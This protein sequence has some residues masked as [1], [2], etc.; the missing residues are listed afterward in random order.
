M[1]RRPSL[2][3]ASRGAT[4]TVCETDRTNAATLAWEWVRTS[5]TT[6]PVTA[7]P[8]AELSGAGGA[9]SAF[10]A[11]AVAL[12]RIPAWAPVR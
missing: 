1:W 4:L 3:A 7:P 6:V 12:S 11:V 2:S 5:A 9:S 10:W 8:V